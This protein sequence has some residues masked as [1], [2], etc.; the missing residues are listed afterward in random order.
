MWNS[1]HPSQAARKRRFAAGFTLI[2]LLVVIAIIAILAGLLLPAMAKAKQ[3][4][5][6]IYC[7]NNEKQLLLC[8]LLYSS[9]YNDR[10]VPNVGF[11]QSA[12]QANSTW[13]VGKVNALPDETNADLLT[14]SLLGYYTK[15]PGIYRCPSDPGNPVGT[16][17][18]RSVSMN[19]YMN[20]IGS[21]ILSNQFRLYYRS[22]SI[23]QPD[24]RFV[25]LDE[26]ATTID[27][28]YFEVLM[29]ADYG[30][31]QVNNLPAN[32]HGLAG[33][34]SYADGHA[35]VH[36]WTTSLVRE[37]P[38]ISLGSVSAPDNA[39]YIWLMQNATEAID[40][41]APSHL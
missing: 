1:K 10:L 14:S 16:P 33:G 39:D 7:M 31:I 19:N 13:A 17:R 34:F 9:D 41:S 2:E 6:G 38:S 26:R 22:A 18:V 20:G 23:R 24:S 21:G 35:G 25:F 12:F 27:D 8:W 40:T 11:A 4:A 29:T 28:A 36:K 15:N 5:Q 30:S 32:Y 3:K 37:P